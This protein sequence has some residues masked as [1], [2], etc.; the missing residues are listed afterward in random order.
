MLMTQKNKDNNSPINVSS[1]QISGNISDSDI[2]Q[3]IGKD[4]FDTAIRNDGYTR[5]ASTIDDNVSVKSVSSKKNRK[6]SK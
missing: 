4:W 2:A 3:K 6:V 5:P 1:G